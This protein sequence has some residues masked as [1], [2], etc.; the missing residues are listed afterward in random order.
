[1]RKQRRARA[2]NANSNIPIGFRQVD[3]TMADHDHR[4]RIAVAKDGSMIT[5]VPIRKEEQHHL[6][7][8]D[9]PTYQ[10]R[11]NIDDDPRSS[12]ILYSDARAFSTHT[13]FLKSDN[14]NNNAIPHINN[15][16]R[17]SSPSTQST[18]TIWSKQ[19]LLDARGKQR[20]KMKLMR[21]SS[22]AKK[23]GNGGGGGGAIL[24][25]V[26][27]TARDQLKRAKGLLHF[28]T[29]GIG[30]GVTATKNHHN[31]NNKNNRNNI[32]T[33]YEESRDRMKKHGKN[34]TAP[35][36]DVSP[37]L[38]HPSSS[39]D[40]TYNSSR[41]P[42]IRWDLDQTSSSTALASAT[43]AAAAAVATTFPRSMKHAK[44]NNDDESISSFPILGAFSA[45][46]EFNREDDDKNNDAQEEDD[47]GG[48]D[49]D[50]KEEQKG[51]QQQQSMIAPNLPVESSPST[52][53]TNIHANDAT[54]KQIQQSPQ[55]SPQSQPNN[56]TATTTTSTTKTSF[57]T[58]L[59]QRIIE[60]QSQQMTLAQ[61]I[62]K[63]QSIERTLITAIDQNL[64]KNRKEWL[65]LDEELK[66]IQWH[67]DLNAEK[68]DHDDDNM[69]QQHHQQRQHPQQ[70]QHQQQQ[71]QQQQQA[72]LQNNRSGSVQT[73]S[74]ERDQESALL[75]QNNNSEMKDP[76]PAYDMDSIG[77]PS[78]TM[79]DSLTFD[80]STVAAMMPKFKT[81]NSSRGSTKGGKRH[82]GGGAVKVT[83]LDPPARPS[84][85]HTKEIL[86][87]RHPLYLRERK[88]PDGPRISAVLRGDEHLGF[89][90][91]GVGAA[92]S[93]AAGGTNVG[94]NMENH[95]PLDATRNHKFGPSPMK[96]PQ[97]KPLPIR[98]LN[99]STLRPPLS[100]RGQKQQ[101]L[102]KFV[103]FNLPSD[104][105]SAELKFDSNNSNSSPAEFVN[106]PITR[107]LPRVASKDGDEDISS[108]QGEHYDV[109][110][111]DE[112]TGDLITNEHYDT[113]QWR[114][115]EHHVLTTEHY[116]RENHH[117]SYP[118]IS[119]DGTVNQN[120]MSFQNF[121]NHNGNRGV[122]SD[123]VETN[124]DLGFMYSVAAVV[125]QTAV[126]RFLAEIAAVERIYAVQVIQTAICNWMARKRN[127]YYGAVAPHSAHGYYE[128]FRVHDTR[129]QQQTKHVM[130]EDDYSQIYY[131]AAT[132][133][134]RCFRGWWVR[135]GLEV[136]HFAATT[137]QSIFR[138]WWTRESLETDAYCATQIQRIMRGYLGRMSYIYD[139][140]SIILV[141]SVARRYMAFYTSAVRLANIIYIQAIY[142]GYTVRLELMR[143]VLNGQEVAAT[144]IQ[145]QWRSYDGQMNYVNTLADILIVQ[146]VARRWLTLKKMKARKNKKSRQ[147]IQYKNP[148]P[149]N[150]Y[151]HSN[152]SM[153]GWKQEWQQ[154]RMKVKKS[155]PMNN[156][157][158]HKDQD[159]YSTPPNWQQHKTNETRSE[160]SFT[161]RR[162]PIE[163]LGI[164]SEDSVDGEG[165][166]DGN[167]S[168]T[169]D[170]LRSWKGRSSK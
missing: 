5:A 48:N 37:P 103:H 129:P 28:T 54:L 142:R 21:P 69:Q 95:V 168:E 44:H 116:S 107:P 140:Y 101:R 79:M 144:V 126:R 125:I 7:Q 85:P 127:P 80:D 96:H 102:K 8:F 112:H 27:Y 32:N 138:G 36:N 132:E 94:S 110:V 63:K 30:G 136:D 72:L 55:Q 2:N 1:M 73:P 117:N 161:N 76:S 75:I 92:V 64:E 139:L 120:Q 121:S 15:I 160:D 104:N 81:K 42:T 130:F 111:Y 153:P 25:D 145:A 29:G 10:S 115:K 159:N 114:D 131:F 13:T 157:E 165:W 133:I 33:H 52:K 65:A 122:S 148:Q 119:N 124:P 50:E 74:P 6:Q 60:I 23:G 152:S 53:T 143:Y 40:P 14:T 170:M 113:Y 31:S 93:S 51:S 162:Q 61:S 20:H 47:E 123:S 62:S 141:Q 156:I 135:D 146:S 57:E 9:S 154:R 100:F 106:R 68:A 169:S 18:S 83:G 56:A 98:P 97:V 167:K 84:P 34:N 150:S 11:N 46:D 66:V 26:R 38:S 134:Q 155:K 49:I 86:D 105:E 71:Q 24:P 12:P 17:D 137:I 158:F 59:Q 88:E 3:S 19:G 109:D 82:P 151:S 91:G 35:A 164:F 108:W 4:Y 39:N 89:I 87:H 22:G 166:Y 118:R 78:L 41:Q 90:R 99:S 163:G 16:N 43:T 147:K 128:P 67:L 58:L 77:D 149:S 70:P 45:F